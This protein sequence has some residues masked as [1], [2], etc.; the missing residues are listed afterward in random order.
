ME[1]LCDPYQMHRIITTLQAAGLP[2]REFAQT[3]A[4]CTLM[5][6]TLFDLLTGQ[7]LEIYASDELRQQALS[8]V[9]VENPRGWR[10]AKEK[11]SKKIDAIVALAMACVAAMEHRG[12]MDSR[13]ARGFN[14]SLHV[15]KERLVADVG[16][17][18][19]GQTLV[20]VPATVIAQQSAFGSIRVLAAFASEGMSLRRHIETVVKPWFVRHA[21][22][23]LQ[24]SQLLFGA[25][26]AIDDRTEWDM[27]QIIEDALGGIWETPDGAWDARR[28]QVLD[29][30]GKATP[31]MFQPALQ[32]DPV[33]A[34]LLVEALSGRW[35]YAND[36]RDKRTAWYYVANALSLLTANLHLGSA[37]VENIRVIS[38]YSGNL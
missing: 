18:Y 34:R 32:I 16:P 25:F 1:I 31:G 20:D 4:N 5:G 12:E 15:S 27:L 38:N 14:K 33:D 11:A 19:V 10:I 24:N 37:P 7:N 13:S 21:R 3:T 22:G 8:T 30:I 6:Q 2:I 36:R 26:E 35:S 28:D 17:I 9:A 29:L 23:Q